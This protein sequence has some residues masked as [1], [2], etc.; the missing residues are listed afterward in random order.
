MAVCLPPVFTWFAMV[1]FTTP[2]VF[3]MVDFRT[4]TS[5]KTVV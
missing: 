4:F 3:Y 2:V 1:R 5:V